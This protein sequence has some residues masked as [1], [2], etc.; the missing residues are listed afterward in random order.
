MFM[1]KFLS[2][3]L[4]AA[5]LAAPFTASAISRSEYVERVE[6]CEALLQQFMGDPDLR[7][8]AEVL[9]RARGIILVNQC[10]AGF[11]S[12]V[13]DGYGVIMVRRPDNSWSLPAVLSAGEGSFGLQIGAST[14]ETIY[15][16]T[17]DRTPRLMFNQKFHV[18]VDA[19]AVVGPRVAAN[20]HSN[21][22]ILTTPIL[23]YT[24][25]RG[26]YAGA[27]LKAGYL[28]R[29]DEANRLLY[30]TNYT[31]PEILYSDWVQSVPEVE[32]LVKLVRQLT[33]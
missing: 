6:T 28:S 18:G 17:D 16:L 27:S 29:N 12:G 14:Q 19:K 15:I 22:E 21:E 8:P 2:F 24:K 4:L 33:N 9:R 1:K 11:V 20:E 26:L 23:V 5:L 32:P 30:H 3:S 31:M 7:I 25:S 13:K 10:R